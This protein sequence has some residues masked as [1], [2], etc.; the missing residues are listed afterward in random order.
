M[1]LVVPPVVVKSLDGALDEDPPGPTAMT[2][3]S[4]VTPLG[5]QLVTI[6]VRLTVISPEAS[7]VGLARLKEASAVV[8]PTA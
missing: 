3:A 6:D 2:R 8:S 4:Y 7:G 5:G 1:Q